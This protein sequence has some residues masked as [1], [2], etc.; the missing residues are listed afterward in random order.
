MMQEL[1]SAT[2]NFRPDNILGEGGFGYVFKGWIEENSTAPAKP[3]TGITVAV[4]RLKQDGLRGHREWMAEV[5]F[6]RQLHH[7]N[8]V[9]LIGYCSEGDQRL[10]VYEFMTRGSLENH[11]FR[12]RMPL[13]WSSRMK[14]A[15]GAAKGLAF[16]HGNREHVIYRDFKTSNILLDLKQGRRGTKP[17]FLHGLLEHM[18]MLR[19]N[20]SRQG[21]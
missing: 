10:L 3:G 18:V 2:A 16:L 17:M 11:L 1:K 4:K 13:S 15:L 9:K 7:P 21:T 19:Q 8:L 5:H 6:L 14:I 12:G 20:M